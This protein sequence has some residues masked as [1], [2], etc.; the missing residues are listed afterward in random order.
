ML[1]PGVN[2]FFLANGQTLPRTGLLETLKKNT[3][4]LFPSQI[5]KIML[6]LDQPIKFC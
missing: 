4:H 3:W 2:L 1:G 6:G 5:N